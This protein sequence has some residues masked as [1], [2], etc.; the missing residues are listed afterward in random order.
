MAA[1]VTK[2][3]D[4]KRRDILEAASAEFQNA[5]FGGVSMDRIA[6]VAQVSKRTVYNHFPSKEELFQAIVVELLD[7]L[8][9]LQT[10][11]YDSES[12]L[13]DQLNGI[14]T[15]YAKR[16]ASNEFL[17]LARVV[18]SR[19]VHSSDQLAEAVGKREQGKQPILRWIKS[20]QEDGRLKVE[21]PL[22][23]ARQ[24][25]ALLMEFVFWPQVLGSERAL[26]VKQQKQVVRT[27]TRMFLAYYAK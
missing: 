22:Q 25:C 27:A 11:P 14:G 8:D 9:Q 2:L 13:E 1:P 20:A 16:V 24:Y 7:R 10:E 23:A 21:N 12:P 26:S 3:T 18:I 5:G 17:K 6:Q 15:A 4:R 19:F